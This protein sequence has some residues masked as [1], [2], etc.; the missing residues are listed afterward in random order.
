MCSEDPVLRRQVLVLQQQLLIDEP[1]YIRQQTRP[2]IVFHADRPSSQVR[3]VESC[4]WDSLTE[5]A[6]TNTTCGTR[7]PSRVCAV[8]RAFNSLIR[9]GGPPTSM[10][11]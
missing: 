11:R 5:R 3:P 6:S 9:F 10:T 8:S 1:C 2:V 4:S 7:A